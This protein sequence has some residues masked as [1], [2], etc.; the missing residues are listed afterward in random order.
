MFNINLL[1]GKRYGQSLY[2]QKRRNS[3][4]S[5]QHIYPEYNVCFKLVGGIEITGITGAGDDGIA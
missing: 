5:I 3:G 2:T 4:L 1:E